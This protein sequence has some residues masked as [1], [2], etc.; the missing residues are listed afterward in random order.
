MLRSDGFLHFVPSG[1]TL[2]LVA[3]ALVAAAALSACGDGGSEGALIRTGIK[4]QS[5]TQGGSCED[6]NVKVMPG[7]LLPNP[8]S[9]A[10]K[11]EFVTTVKLTKAADGVACSGDTNTIPMAPGKWTFKAILPSNIQTCEKDVPA[12]GGVSV[13]FKD[14]DAACN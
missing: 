6:V 3:G 8:P 2:G 1:R 4:V 13:S 11:G 14:G 9:N 5:I 10:N 12:A 7:E